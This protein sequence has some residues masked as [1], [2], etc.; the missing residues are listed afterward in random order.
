MWVCKQDEMNNWIII[1]KL[2]ANEYKVIRKPITKLWNIE[3]FQLK[4]Q[5]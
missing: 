4:D 5:R 2:D 1:S 3:C